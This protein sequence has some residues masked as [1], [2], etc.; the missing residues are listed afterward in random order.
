MKKIAFLALCAM[1]AACQKTEFEEPTKPAEP[2]QWGQIDISD[3][4]KFVFTVKGDFG[5]AAFTRAYLQADGKEMTDLWVYDYMEGQLV[6][7]LHQ[8]PS[9]ANW[10]KP[11][12][13]LPYGQHHVYFVASRGTDPSV[14]ETDHII[15]WGSVRDT[16]WKDYEVSVVSTSNGNRAVTLD[17]VVTKLR[18]TVNDEV[19]TN[20]AQLSVT[21]STWYYGINYTSGAAVSAQSKEMTVDI[22]ASYIGTSGQLMASFFSISA[23]DEWTTNISVKAKAT[24]GSVLG[25]VSISGSPFKANRATEYSGN[26]F[27]SG[28]S[29]DISVN[30]AWESPLEKTW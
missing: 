10:G 5:A 19:P 27:G 30:E 29:L 24:D 15:S 26:L 6:Q 16:F 22:P 1:L 21:P 20:C 18:L 12:M 11:E 23:P 25:S 2:N 7:K 4:R 14:N 28:G 3:G 8:T 9:D 13:I 17:R